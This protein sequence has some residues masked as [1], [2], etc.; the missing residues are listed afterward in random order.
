MD[1]FQ[2]IKRR[3]TRA[4]RG[5][6]PQVSGT[7]EPRRAHRSRR[8]PAILEALPTPSFKAPE[9]TEQQIRERAYAIWLA[10]GRQPGRDAENWHQAECELRAELAAQPADAKPAAPAAE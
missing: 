2:D 1:I 9:P 5:W 4:N 10:G 8:A 7:E 6:G 3:A